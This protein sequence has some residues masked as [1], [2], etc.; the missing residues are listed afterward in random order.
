MLLDGRNVSD[1]TIY[2]YND[3]IVGSI[4]GYLIDRGLANRYGFCSISDKNPSCGNLLNNSKPNNTQDTSFIYWL[5]ADVT[6]LSFLK[7]IITIMIDLMISIPLYVRYKQTQAEKNVWKDKAVKY[8]IAIGTFVLYVNVTRFE[9]AYLSKSSANNGGLANPPSDMTMT[10]FLMSAC[11]TF[12]NTPN[13]EKGDAG[14]AVMNK[15]MKLFIVMASMAIMGLYQLTKGVTSGFAHNFLRGGSSRRMYGGMA[16]ILV[17]FV[18][19]GY[20]LLRP[21]AIDNANPKPMPSILM[22]VLGI[23]MMI[24]GFASIALFVR[25]IASIGKNTQ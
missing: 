9:W 12:L 7:F 22:H 21:E 13:V 16:T 18:A 24:F 5:F 4:L 2:M 19:S 23:I 11:M 10:V 14:Y 1:D 25:Y 3:L 17:I 6:G 15:S 20:M 8:A